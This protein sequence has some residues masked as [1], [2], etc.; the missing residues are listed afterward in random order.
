MT[1]T[2]QGSVSAR[3]PFLTPRDHTDTARKPPKMAI[4]ESIWFKKCR[5][6]QLLR[7]ENKKVPFMGGGYPLG[8]FAL[9]EGAL[10]PRIPDSRKISR[11]AGL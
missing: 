9:C 7:V 10:R 6:M 3:Q 4:G 1:V 8:R 11:P 5:E 2:L